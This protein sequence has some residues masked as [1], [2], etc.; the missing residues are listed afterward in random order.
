MYVRFEGH[1]WYVQNLL[2]RIYETAVPQVSKG[3]VDDCLTEIIRSES[4][5]FAR[6]YRLLTN[7]QA[8]LLRAIADE[9]AVT[10]IN[11]TA[12]IT[13]HHL[14]GTSS[15]NKA[16]D[17]LINKEYVYASSHGYIVYDR[18]MGLWLQINKI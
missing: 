2:N 6:L 17:A 1:T 13:A 3:V 16:L 4:D 12:F 8:Q 11:A 10:A 7:N 5:D 14:K 18:F 9:G 15:I